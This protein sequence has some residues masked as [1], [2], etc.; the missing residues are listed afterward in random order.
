MKRA[1]TVVEMLVV[2]GVVVILA[3]LLAPTF[4][5][6]REKA[7][8]E[9]CISNMKQIG[10]G[11]MQY[12]RDYD[13]KYPL[14]YANHDGIAGYDPL[15]DKGWADIVQPYIKS[16]AVFQCMSESDGYSAPL[17][18]SDYW[19][20]APMLGISQAKVSKLS[21]T[22]MF[23]D[24]DQSSAAIVATHGAIAYYGDAPSFK[25]NGEIWDITEKTN[26]KGGRR[27]LG[28]MNFA[29]VDGHVKWFKPEN[30]GADAIS[31]GKPTFRIN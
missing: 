17:M 10:L 19:L 11:F 18:S 3:G 27:H 29:F 13:E 1:F 25:Y 30:V 28:G 6:M 7:R 23:G 2:I 31:K 22:V 20:A 26:G 4:S 15:V 9:A 21:L 14:A 16:V 8:R 24:S 12:C 5:K